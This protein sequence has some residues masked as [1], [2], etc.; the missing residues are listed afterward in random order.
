MP[1]DTRTT[2]NDLPVEI[3]DLILENLD[4]C[5]LANLAGAGHGIG[6]LALKRTGAFESLSHTH[7]GS[8]FFV[9]PRTPM[10]HIAAIG[11][12]VVWYPISIKSIT[13]LAVRDDVHDFLDDMRNLSVLIAHLLFLPDP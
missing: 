2:I 11:A 7:L 8:K 13:Y 3:L 12:A 4:D 1:Q 5:A 6:F 10:V 9:E